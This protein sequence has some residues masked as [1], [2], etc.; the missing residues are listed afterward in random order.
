MRYPKL[1]FGLLRV[2]GAATVVL[3]LASACST[4]AEPEP[5]E[6]PPQE[7]TNL[8][9]TVRNEA[10]VDEWTLTCEPDGGTHPDPRQACVF[11]DLAKQWGQD[12]FAPT[13]ADAICGQVFGG[14]Q[15]ATV[16]GVWDGKP[17]DAKFD[18]ANS[19]EISRWS[20]AIPLL[21]V[22]GGAGEG[23]AAGPR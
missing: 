12:P 3:I 5:S 4:N 15:T 11:L 21:V 18:L 6:Q 1:P 2:V 13:P 9:I 22:E 16:T 17:V 7:G 14:P 20:N 19:C 23:G 10:Q 8:T